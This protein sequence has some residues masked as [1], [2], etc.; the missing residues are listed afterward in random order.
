MQMKRRMEG[1]TNRLVDGGVM[2][3]Q[4][5]TQMDQGR[6]HR[7]MDGPNDVSMD[8]LEMDGSFFLGQ[9][10]VAREVDGSYPRK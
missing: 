8:G 1:W 2:E 9:A 3:S 7:G 4:I 10:D 5:D 6:E